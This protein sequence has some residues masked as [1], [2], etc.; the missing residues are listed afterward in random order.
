MKVFRKAS[1]SAELGHIQTHGNNRGFLVGLSLREGHTRRTFRQSRASTHHFGAG[2]LYVRNLSDDYTADL[3][4]AFDFMLFEIPSS[5]L[6]KFA[7]DADHP[8]LSLE[9]TIA[10]DDPFLANLGWAIA[11]LLADSSSASP[12]FADLMTLAIGTHLA[13]RYGSRPRQRTKRGLGFTREQEVTA[14]EM[15]VANVA[16]ERSISD[17]ATSMDMSSSQFIR[18]FGAAVGMTP[19]RW[20]MEQRIKRACDLLRVSHNSLDQVAA[21]CGFSDQ[22]HF[23]R[24]FAKHVGVPPGKWRRDV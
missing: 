12:V 15:L 8:T 7:E 9:P 6:S 21:A 23:T 19:H 13:D 17:I 11:P 2:S 3:S 1:H 24:V 14:K 20:L 10:A 18:M 22:S 16:G 5:A 4:G